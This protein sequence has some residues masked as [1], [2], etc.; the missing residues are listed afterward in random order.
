M[1]IL[2]S[3]D[4]CVCAYCATLVETADRYICDATVH[5][6][7][8]LVVSVYERS[9][10]E[11]PADFSADKYLY[12]GIKASISPAWS[13]PAQ[14]PEYAPKP[15]PE[16]RLAA[17]ERENKALQSQLAASI[18]SNQMLEDCLVEMAGVVYA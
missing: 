14:E 18:Q 8:H 17:L 1:Y 5:I 16:E 4:N 7:K 13:E 6:Q 10:E 11:L 3:S 9:Q 15:T 2:C 12:D